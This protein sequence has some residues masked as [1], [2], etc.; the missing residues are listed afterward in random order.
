[1]IVMYVV[2]GFPSP[3]FY[4]EKKLEFQCDCP[5]KFLFMVG[6]TDIKR[7]V[8]FYMTHRPS[9]STT[10]SLNALSGS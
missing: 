5:G 2:E 8:H 6:C 3:N 9:W 4:C 10:R 7:V 1:M